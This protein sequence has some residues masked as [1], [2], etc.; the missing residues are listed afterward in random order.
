VGEEGYSTEQSSVQISIVLPE[1]GYEKNYCR[2]A[3]GL[4]CILSCILRPSSRAGERLRLRGTNQ[5][6]FFWQ[7]YRKTLTASTKEE[8]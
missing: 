3:P 2:F 4:C 6:R 7:L 5:P 8:T 1:K